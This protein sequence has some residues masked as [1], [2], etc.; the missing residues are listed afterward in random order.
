[1]ASGPGTLRPWSIPSLGEISDFAKREFSPYPAE[2]TPGDPRPGELLGRWLNAVSTMPSVQAVRSGFT[3]PG[4]V[5]SGAAP[6]EVPSQNP[7][8]TRVGDL[9]N[10]AMMGGA[11]GTGAEAGTAFGAGMARRGRGGRLPPREPTEGR[12][13][14]PAEPA[15]DPV[16]NLADVVMGKPVRGRGGDG[17]VIT[18]RDNGGPPL[19]PYP[20]Y[21]EVYPEPGPPEWR[22]DKTKGTYYW[23]KEYTPEVK[24]F[25]KAR[26]KIREDMDKNG[27]TPFFDVSQRYDVDPTNYPIETDTMG[28]VPAKQST[29][30]NDMQTIG[31]DA[32]RARL[33]EAYARGKEMPNTENW[34]YVGQLEKAFM[35]ELGPEE[36]RKA[37][38]DRFATGMGA[39]TGG[40]APEGNFLMMQWANYLRQHGMPTPEEAHQYPYPIGGRYGSNNMEAFDKVMDAG[41]GFGEANPK[42]LNFGANFL[43]HP[44]RATM[45]EVM[46][47]GMTPGKQMPPPGKYGLYEGVAHEEAAKAGVDPREFQGVAWSGFKSL[48]AKPGKPYNEGQPFMQT[49]NESIERTHRLTGMPRDEIVRRGLVRYEIPMYAGGPAGL[50]GFGS[51]G[52]QQTAGQNR[53]M[54]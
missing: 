14:L 15:I 47:S 45:D 13:P 8:L 10:L 11:F 48:K 6:M 17:R 37:F 21:A 44:N 34:Y 18:N 2:T 30:E 41:G 31:S 26:A 28:I 39:T 43:G 19:A 32:S 33:Q 7:D 1:M 40:A 38:R 22:L 49:V 46:T 23:G 3:L 52:I 4:D 51:F 42:R 16:A 24:K 12:A 29:I 25:E 35:D 50:G 9:A 27:Y 54:E 36:G 20:Q 53:D 5:A